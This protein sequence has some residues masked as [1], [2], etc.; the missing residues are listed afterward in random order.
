MGE[1][2]PH[3]TAAE[4]RILKILWKDGPCTV[5]DVKRALTKAGTDE[6]AYT[7]VMTM[8]KQLAKK[9]ALNVDRTSQKFVYAPA[10]RREK[11]LRSRLTQFVQ[12]VFDGRG[13]G[14]KRDEHEEKGG[15]DAWP[16]YRHGIS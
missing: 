12:T 4:L 8:M 1:T 7:T 5:R 3:I 13:V 15:Q 2:M 9:G 16:S 11:V 10:V 6:P 14:G